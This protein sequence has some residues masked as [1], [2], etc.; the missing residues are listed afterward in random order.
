[1]ELAVDQ[2]GEPLRVGQKYLVDFQNEGGSYFG[3]PHEVKFLGMALHFD[4]DEDKIKYINEEDLRG[5]EPNGTE[6]GS[7]RHEWTFDKLGSSG[8]KKSRKQRRN[9]KQAQKSRRNR[10]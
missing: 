5:P 2:F 8:G 4:S 1:M 9:R 7:M 6:R 10:K 3:N